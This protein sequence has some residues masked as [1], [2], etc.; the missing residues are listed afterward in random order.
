MNIETLLIGKS[1]FFLK[2]S[3]EPMFKKIYLSLKSYFYQNLNTTNYQIKTQDKK[4]TKYSN[5]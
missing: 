2:I 3:K 1:K 5:W 4:Q